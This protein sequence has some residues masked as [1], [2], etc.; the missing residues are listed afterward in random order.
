VCFLDECDMRSRLLSTMSA[1][2]CRG[3][4]SRSNDAG[5]PSAVAP[6]SLR[7]GAVKLVAVA[8]LVVAAACGGGWLFAES[9][10]STAQ[11][12]AKHGLWQEVHAPLARYLWIH[13][14]SPRAN[15]LAAEA[16]VKDDSLP[17]V[18]RVNDSLA[19]L[20]LIPD[21]SPAAVEARIAEARVELFLRY[22]PMAA[23]RSLAEAIDLDGTAL[24][25]H[26]L[27]W[28]L[29]E[30]TGRADDAEATFWTCYDLSAEVDRPQRLR[31]WYVSQFFPLTSTAELDQ[32]M[33]FRGSA[34]ESGA[35]V[36]MRRLQRFRL[37][38]PHEPVPHAALAQLFLRE[39][40][41][42]LALDVL[43]EAASELTTEQQKN[44]FILGVVVET[45]LELGETEPALETFD[46]WVSPREGRQYWLV[47]GRV[48]QEAGDNPAEAALAYRE[49][50]AGWPGVID[51]RTMNR[52]AG[53]LSRTGN[54][55]QAAAE[56]QRVQEV[57]QELPQER[58]QQLLDSLAT[59]DDPAVAEAMAGFYRAIGRDR[60]AA[61]WK[62]VEAAGSGSAAGNVGP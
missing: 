48:M 61:A 2:H 55:E 24:E 5:R 27:T 31:E 58:L 50:L 60:E 19:H 62:A 56:R 11:R 37:A 35:S 13:P 18:R 7:T 33:G 20:A 36:E 14:R 29:L 10:L 53:C 17:L 32:L 49:A 6:L 42:E 38:E 21:S 15:L 26:L 40:E 54:A 41:P 16:V 4:G 45:L 3:E 25:P 22:E 47:R 34:A 52:L 43:D 9:G 1:V 44:P 39:N 46:R 59:P 23:A 57:Q 8:V 28:K 51:W 30:L 12:L